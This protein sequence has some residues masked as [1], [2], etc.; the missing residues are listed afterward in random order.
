MRIARALS[1]MNWKSWAATCGAVAILCCSSAQAERNV[2]MALRQ[3]AGKGDLPAIRSLLV[4]GANPTQSDALLAAIENEQRRA[5]DYLL[6][7]G[8]DPNAWT[9]GRD[10]L[11]AGAEGSPVFVAAKLGNKVFLKDLLRHGARLDAASTAKQ[12][13]GD[14]PLI[15]AARR[16]QVRALSLLIDCGADVNYKNVNGRTALLEATFSGPTEV[17]LVKLLVSHGADP[18]IKDA[19]GRSARGTSFNYGSPEARQ[20]IEKAKPLGPFQRPDEL[21]RIRA[22]LMYKAGCDLSSADY[23]DRTRAAYESWRTPRAAALAIIE[24]QSDFQRQRALTV[25]SLAQALAIPHETPELRP[26]MDEYHALCDTQLIKE[27]NDAI[28]GQPLSR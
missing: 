23:E 6:S 19:Q 7:H 25:Q 3:A 15:I 17:E 21:E 4:Q 9:R 13:L 26:E 22:V 20:V 28:T 12:T 27:F 14:T 10:N 1:R 11:P 16:G 24:S 2:D 5:M 18:D 8:A